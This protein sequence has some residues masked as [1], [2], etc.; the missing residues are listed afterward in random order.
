MVFVKGFVKFN[1]RSYG[2]MVSHVTCFPQF[3]IGIF[4]IQFVLWNVDEKHFLEAGELW[5]RLTF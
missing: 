3:I 1:F 2:R 5:I 4:Y